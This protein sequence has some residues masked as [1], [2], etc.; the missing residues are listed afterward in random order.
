[1]ARKELIE[2]ERRISEHLYNE[3]EIIKD[4]LE[5]DL[6]PEE[7]RELKEYM[8]RHPY[9]ELSSFLRNMQHRSIKL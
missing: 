6:S 2:L 9:H 3:A 8:N 1:M 7:W 5:T 4:M